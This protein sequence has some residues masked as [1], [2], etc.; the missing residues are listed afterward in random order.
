MQNKKRM[1]VR[2]PNT[3][4]AIALVRIPLPAMILVRLLLNER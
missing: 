4:V 3:P 1:V 2:N